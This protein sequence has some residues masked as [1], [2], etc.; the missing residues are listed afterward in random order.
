[1]RCPEIYSRNV[2]PLGAAARPDTPLK[3][4]TADT[5][6][7]IGRKWLKVQESKLSAATLA[8]ADWVLTTF[9]FR[10][11]GSRR[12]G[13]IEATDV[14]RLLRRVESRGKHET[15]HRTRQRC[16]HIYRSGR[17]GARAACGSRTSQVT[18]D[19]TPST[20]LRR[21]QCARG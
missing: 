21:R 17:L 9:V 14:P 7:A 11:I 3:V 16:S 20:A 18:D 1:L 4:A 5:F 19:C 13:E 2:K 8:K 6:K 15:V 10:H 12:I